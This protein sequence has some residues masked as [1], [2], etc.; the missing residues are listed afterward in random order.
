MYAY[1][2]AVFLNK[3]IIILKFLIKHIYLF[4]DPIEKWRS[5]RSQLRVVTY[6]CLCCTSFSQARYIIV[7]LPAISGGLFLFQRFSPA[8]SWSH[9]FSNV[10]WKM[11]FAQE[12]CS[13]D[14][15]DGGCESSL[16][17]TLLTSSI[18]YPKQTILCRANYKTVMQKMAWVAGWLW[19]YE[20]D[21]KRA[22]GVGRKKNNFS[23]TAGQISGRLEQISTFNA[24]L[25]SKVRG[26]LNLKGGGWYLQSRFL[27][28]C[29]ITHPRASF[30]NREDVMNQ[31]QRHY[32]QNT[33]LCR[34]ISRWTH[35]YFQIKCCKVKQS[36]EIFLLYGKLL[37]W[38]I[39]LH[40]KECVL[41]H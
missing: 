25:E 9:L 16:V 36:I 17:S 1:F 28:I 41:F 14:G 32:W 3:A 11:E 13:E 20:K 19:K 15:D 39:P 12:D 38:L 37:I 10:N 31:R 4:F 33:N 27:F 40:W 8:V 2:P 26:A 29:L 35:F 7:G 5:S 24:S 6:E 18:L 22:W 23:F 21:M 34:K 30:I